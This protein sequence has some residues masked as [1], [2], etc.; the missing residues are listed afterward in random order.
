[1]NECMVISEQNIQQVLVEAV[2]DM[3]AIVINR[4]EK[5]VEVIGC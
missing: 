3:V 5:D 1:M 2:C 4:K